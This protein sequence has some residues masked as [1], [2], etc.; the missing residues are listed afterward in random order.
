MDG[1]S[2]SVVFSRRTFPLHDTA[3]ASSNLLLP[4]VLLNTEMCSLLRLWPHTLKRT[5]NRR[6]TRG[7]R[8]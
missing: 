7:C 2:G 4:P 6:S 1:C 5:A 8:P 3:L